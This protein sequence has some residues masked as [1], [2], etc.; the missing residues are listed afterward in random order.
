ME[1]KIVKCSSKIRGYEL[2]FVSGVSS[3]N[4]KLLLDNKFLI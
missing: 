1:D 2:N 3:S 4:K